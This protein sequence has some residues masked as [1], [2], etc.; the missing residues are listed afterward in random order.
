MSKVEKAINDVSEAC[1]KHLQEFQKELISWET[2]VTTL[3]NVTNAILQVLEDQNL[4]TDDTLASAS[5]KLFDDHRYNMGVVR[6]SAVLKRAPAPGEL[7]DSP[8]ERLIAAA[9]KGLKGG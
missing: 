3:W 1:E 5:R 7:R 9:N 2:K 8:V 4:I 6:A